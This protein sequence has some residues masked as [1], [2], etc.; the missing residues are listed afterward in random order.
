MNDVSIT[1]TSGLRDNLYTR[2]REFI[3]AVFQHTW[4]V[5]GRFYKT[6]KLSL[7]SNVTKIKGQIRLAKIFQFIFRVPIMLIVIG[8]SNGENLAKPKYMKSFGYLGLALN[9]AKGGT[10]ADTWQILFQTY[11]DLL[12]LIQDT[13]PIVLFN[14]GG[15]HVLQGR[16]DLMEPA[17]IYLKENFPKSFNMEIPPIYS[18][19]ISGLNGN[20]SA[21]E[22]ENNVKLTNNVI[23]DLWSLRAINLY[24]LFIDPTTLSDDIVDKPVMF[25]LGDLVH[26]SDLG[27]QIRLEY[28]N[29]FFMVYFSAF[30]NFLEAPEELLSKEN[31]N[32]YEQI[33]IDVVKSH[34]EK[35]T[36]KAVKK[37]VAKK[38]SKKRK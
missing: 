17:L 33:I 2:Y 3:N 27:N 1:F 20:L 35:K 23:N 15:N 25:T 8:D 34:K 13:F 18:D 31:P 14:I 24:D 16:M 32:E 5:V 6:D 38:K 4:S 26:F 37:V 9:I 21:K 19:L 11:P 10:R 28:I 36:K 12:K 30:Q 29:Y 7:E 22:I